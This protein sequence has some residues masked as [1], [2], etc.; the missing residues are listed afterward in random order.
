MDAYVDPMNSWMDQSVI[1]RTE[2]WTRQNNPQF[3]AY[4]CG[5]LLDDPNEPP[6]SDSAYPGQVLQKSKD[7]TLQFYKN[8]LKPM[9]PKVVDPSGALD[10]TKV[11]D[12]NDG[13]GAARAD[14]QYYR[15]NIDPSERYVLSVAGST[16]YRLKPGGSGFTNL[17]LAGDWTLNGLNVGCVES[18]T[19]G[20][21]EASAAIS[22][23]PTDI[24]GETD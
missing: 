5:P 15:V 3:L 8:D 1:L 22:G 21:V 6:P 7:S 13:V 18:A 4:F 12:P 24:P 17:F 10:W 2:T 23:Y 11:F 9:W 14:G 19:L 16:K 20:G